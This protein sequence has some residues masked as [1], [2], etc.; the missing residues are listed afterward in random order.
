MTGITVVVMASFR[1]LLVEIS[2]IYIMVYSTVHIGTYK[3]NHGIYYWMTRRFLVGEFQL[4]LCAEQS[5]VPADVHRGCCVGVICGPL[6][7]RGPDAWQ[8]HRRNICC[9]AYINPGVT[10][11]HM[12]VENTAWRPPW[13][14]PLGLFDAAV[15]L[16]RQVDVQVLGGEENIF[17]LPLLHPCFVPH[18]E[19]TV[20]LFIFIGKNTGMIIIIQVSYSP[21]TTSLFS[22]DSK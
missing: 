10:A 2:G 7:A 19:P 21:P 8:F 11:Y 14:L 20:P 22:V 6:S 16:L 17:V 12:T 3:Y 9:C 15:W 5:F 4:Q 18:P 1:C 13:K